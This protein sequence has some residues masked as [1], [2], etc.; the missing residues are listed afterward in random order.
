MT[1]VAGEPYTLAER[2]AAMSIPTPCAARTKP[3]RFA[4]TFW[5]C[6]A[7]AVLL[8]VSSPAWTQTGASED[9]V[10]LPEGPGSLEGVGENVDIDPNMG[11]M[12]YSV[13]IALPQGYAD[14]TPSL[15]LAYS[16][17]GGASVVGMGWSLAT[18]SIER[19]TYRRV[20]RYDLGDDFAGVGG[21]LVYMPGSSPRVYRSRYENSFIRHTWM[22]SGDGGEGY[23]VAEY[24]D[25]SRGYFGARPDGSLVPN[26]RV[27]GPDGTFRYMLVE[28]VNVHG[29]RV[30]YT[31][32]KDG[33]ISLLARVEWVFVDGEAAYSAELDYEERRDD[34]GLEYFSDAGSGFEM[35]LTQRLSGVRV[36]NQGRLQRR[37]AL[38]FESYAEAGNFTRLRE[39]VRFGADDGRYP[40][41]FQFTYSSS[42][43]QRP[44]VVELDEALGVNVAGGNATLLDINGDALPDLLDATQ[45]GAHRFFYNIAS[46]DGM[47]RFDPAPVPSALGTRTSHPLGSATTH[48]L[49]LNG[50]GFTDM[51]NASTGEVLVNR[52]DGDWTMAGGDGLDELATA[53]TQ[54]FDSGDGSLGTLR[55][56][57]YNN[58]KLIDVMRSDQQSTSVFENRGAEGFV[59]VDVEP[60]GASFDGDAIELNDMNGDGLLDP[61][62][63]Q[64]GGLR[65]RLNHG[66]GRW[67]AWVD[68]VGLPID[69]DDIPLADLE[70]LNGDGL[71]DLVVVEGDTVRYALNNNTTAFH[72]AV[73]VTSDHVDGELPVRGGEDTVLYA[74]LNGNGSQ[75]IVWITPLGQVTYLDLFP[76]RAN[77]MARVENGLGMVTDVTYGTAAQ[78]MARD[79]GWQAWRH[80]LPYPMQ[81][82]SKIDRWDRLTNLHEEDEYTYHNGYYDGVEKQFR[83]FAEV[84]IR[85]NADEFQEAGVTAM[86]YDVGDLDPY[87]NGLQLYASLESGGRKLN[88]V[89]YHHEDCEVDG[90]AEG[91]EFAVRHLCQRWSESTMIEGLPEDRWVVTRNET[92]Y[93]GYGKAVLTANLGVVSIGGEGCAP[94]ERSPEVFGEPCGAQC[95][96]DESYQERAFIEPGEATGGLWMIG[97]SWRLRNYGIPGSDNHTESLH[98]FDGLPLGRLSRGLETR[99]TR[100]I[101]RDRDDVIEAVRQ[102]YDTHGNTIRRLDANGTDSAH[103]HT[104]EFT[105]DPTGLRVTRMEDLVEDEFGEPYRLR[106]EF[107]YEPL[108]DRASSATEWQIVRDGVAQGTPRHTIFLYDEFGRLVRRIRPGPDVDLG[109]TEEYEYELGDPVSRLTVKR[110][111]E[112][113]GEF[114]L[115]FSTCFDGRG[116]EYQTRTQ[117]GPSEVLVS[118]FTLFNV[119]GKPLRQYQPFTSD[120]MSCDTAEPDGVKFTAMFSDADGRQLRRTHPDGEI[121]G[122][123]SVELTRYEPL[124]TFQFDRADSD[125]GS[126]HHDTPN[127]TEVDGQGQIV[128]ERRVLESGGREATIDVHYTDLGFAAGYTDAGANQKVQSFD[129]LGRAV[130]VDNPNADGARV[131]EYDDLGQVVREE[132]ERGVVIRTEYDGLNRIVAKYD[133]A[134]RDGTLIDFRY[135]YPREC[136]EDVCTFAEA[137]LVEMSFPGL[138]GRNKEWI[139][140][141]ARGNVA[142]RVRVID[143]VEFAF[144]FAFDNADR[145]T[146]ITYP[147]G[148]V[149]DQRWDQAS[150]LVA[151]PGYLHDLSYDDRGLLHT[152]GCADG[153]SMEMRYDDLRRTARKEIRAGSTIL[154]G[155]AYAHDRADNLLGIE[156]LVD[157]GPDFGVE[158]AFDAWY[159]LASATRGAETLTYGYD[160][161]DNVRSITSSLGEGSPVHRG[162]FDYELD[163]PNAATS[164]GDVALEYDDAGNVVRRGAQA[165]EWDAFGRLVAMTGDG[166]DIRSV[167]GPDR[168][169]YAR[170]S[171]EETVYYLSDDFEVRDGVASTYVRVDRH[172]AVRIESDALATQ[173]LGDAVEDGQVNAADAYAT[174]ETVPLRHATRRLLMETTYLHHDHLGSNTLATAAGEGGPIVLGQRSYH[175]YGQVAESWGQ[176][177]PYGFT[178]QETESAGLVRFRERYYDPGSARWLSLDPKFDI[179]TP[180]QLASPAEATNGYSYVANSPV[181]NFDRTGLD[182]TVYHPELGATDGDLSISRQVN[183]H[184]YR[185]DGQNVVEIGSRAG[186]LAA[187]GTDNLITIVAHGSW[188]TKVSSST[189]HLSPKA[190][191]RA[192]IADGLGTGDK[193]GLTIEL[194]ACNAGSHTKSGLLWREPY[195]KRLASAL[196]SA[197]VSGVS[198]VGYGGVVTGADD[199]AALYD[200]GSQELSP[201]ADRKVTYTATRRGVTQTEG[202]SWY[203]HKT[204]SGESTFAEITSSKT[205]PARVKERGTWAKFKRSSARGWASV[206]AKF[207]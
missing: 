109:A 21:Q 46:E 115:R 6:V 70:D 193:G 1:Y 81:V 50:D 72:D 104:R 47:A 3:A 132:D 88:E 199:V 29:H 91:S 25:G 204:T 205:T 119:R 24:P 73:T 180:K 194:L 142:R 103:A 43:D 56:I 66:W 149:I 116:R 124:V 44:V 120:S 156:D 84:E 65:Y 30:R 82:V 61:V 161:I 106:R 183:H 28:S 8:T 101:W 32:V 154:Q 40:T 110:R 141:D 192:M 22:E 76:V 143:G 108:F 189:T 23:W 102:V 16:S 144:E 87:R 157:A 14:S 77:L 166:V 179:S 160:D 197:G 17:G 41:S 155:W 171:P 165:L 69:D 153:T 57:D 173:I 19:M 127:I 98:Y 140:Y 89:V 164:V 134:D 111:S 78:H 135:D 96:G 123:S 170:H 172:R 92:D 95:L 60:I 59:A 83:G 80:K 97:R 79:G 182:K 146:S 190:L 145:V 94:C 45:P 128:R 62:R 4:T 188:G 35:L 48:V 105:Y 31:Y 125:E 12:Q 174:G 18:P 159:R 75:D 36:L 167:Y 151:V 53:F 207:Q 184:Q 178:G 68:I 15:S 90:V 129:L 198:V 114:D 74:D 162:A 133:E 202:S 2:S 126:P 176:L 137:K 136:P 54:Q 139:G 150:R 85:A 10:S 200:G 187:N 186:G 37:Y 42:R 63:I 175:A 100:K 113:G 118:G 11:L 147:D 52:G 195:A 107:A 5:R 177:D 169:R 148:T 39:V 64:L 49:D 138:A 93:D 71:A 33:R 206:K 191:A 112:S 67:G 9:R 152:V 7:A 38:Q 185:R 163:R 51:V 181:G 26:A 117:V 158:F 86:R 203:L 196:R 131:V 20:P 27:T 122:T 121:Y 130:A 34:T 13:H 168:A 99:A 201:R 58:D 55:F